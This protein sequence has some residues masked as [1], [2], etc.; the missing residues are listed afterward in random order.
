MGNIKLNELCDRYEQLYTGLVTD[1][2]DSMGY[3]DQTMN[4]DI[5]PID[6]SQIVAG[7]AFPAMGR[8]NRSVD[9]NEQVHRFLRMLGEAPEHSCLVL[10][11]NANDSAQIGELTTTALA[12]QDCRGIVTDGGIRDTQAVLDQGYPVFTRYR[13]PADSIHRWELLNWDCTVTVGGVEVS[14]GDIVFADIDGVAVVPEELAEEVL[15]E[16]ESMRETENSVRAAIKDGV[17][18]EEAYNRHETF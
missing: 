12:A 9:Y 5:G 6:Q 1:V 14:P 16:A 10:N 18:P 8:R 11:A 17:T 3:K 15:L 7:V 13:T 4:S 2:L